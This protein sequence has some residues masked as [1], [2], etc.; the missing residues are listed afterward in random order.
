MLQRLCETPA[1][2]RL[3]AITGI[4]EENGIFFSVDYFSGFGLNGAS[5]NGANIIIPFH[6]GN[7]T[8]TH[9]YTAH[10]DLDPSTTQGAN[11]NTAAVAQLIETAIRLTNSDY[12]GPVE[13]VLTDLEEPGNG[14][15]ASGAHHYAKQ[16]GNQPELVLVLDVTGR[17]DVLC[18]DQTSRQQIGVLRGYLAAVGCSFPLISRQLPPADNIGFESADIDS[19]L[20]C[21]LPDSEKEHPMPS[22][23]RVIHSNDDHFDRLDIATQEWIPDLVVRIANEVKNGVS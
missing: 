18:A 13:I 17:G 22:T 9:V 19:V 3:E 21:V 15:F 12:V 5:I 16:L 7:H 4:L 10:Y 23:W 20:V 2:E 14:G 1:A 6:G 8:P 11:D